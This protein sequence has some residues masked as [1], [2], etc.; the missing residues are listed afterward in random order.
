A[1][2]NGREGK[3]PGV[4]SMASFASAA[5]AVRCAAQI[6]ARLQ[7][8]DPAPAELRVRI[9]IAAGEPV[10]SNEDLFGSTVQLAARLCAA[11]SPM[12]S[13]V[14]SVVA[15]LCIGKGLNFDFVGEREL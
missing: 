11:A 13:L 14:S 3:H 1:E 6:H 5:T 4:G 9:G 2:V 8:H 10:E 12:Q 15:D 7:A